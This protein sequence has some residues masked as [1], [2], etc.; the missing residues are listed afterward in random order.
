[1]AEGK[2][3]STREDYLRAIYLLNK[4]N[5]GRIGIRDITD[6]LDLGRSTVS[7]RLAELSENKLI[8]FEKYSR[9]ILTKKGSEIARKLTYKHRIIEVFLYKKLKFSKDEIHAEANKMEHAFSD[10]TIRKLAALLRFPRRDPHGELIEEI[11]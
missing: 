3:T 8:R 4:R 10:K 6:Y 2:I 9:I 11:L 7:E 5:N 1:M